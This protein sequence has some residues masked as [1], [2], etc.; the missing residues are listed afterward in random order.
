MIKRAA[1]PLALAGLAFVHVGPGATWLATARRRLPRLAG[2]GRDDHVA[3]T[4]DDGP[5]PRST[6]FFLDELGWLGCRATFFVLGEMLE[7]HPEVGRRIVAEGH[8]MAVHGW[9]HTNALVTRPGAVTSEMGRTADLVRSFTGVRPVWYRP[10][11]GVLS[12]EALVATRLHRLRPV[13]CTV[14]GQDWTASATPESVMARLRPGLGGRRDRRAARHR[15]HVPPPAAGVRRSAR[16][17]RWS[18][19]AAGRGCGSARCATTR[20]AAGAVTCGCRD[21]QDTAALLDISADIVCPVPG[22]AKPEFPRF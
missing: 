6:P 1:L 19:S 8:E 18:A 22:T 2:A 14:S 20:S 10:P 9:R 13:L 16:C 7:R 4:F 5:D 11:Y 21:R 15:S 3:L 17:P 12:A